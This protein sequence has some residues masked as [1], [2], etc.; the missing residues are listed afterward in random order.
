MIGNIEVKEDGKDGKVL[1]ELTLSKGG[2]L[3]KTGKSKIYAS[4]TGFI[5]VKLVDGVYLLNL[6]L[7][8][9]G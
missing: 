1:L 5:E 6:N 8:K 4:T 9:K 2:Q 7:I 3:S